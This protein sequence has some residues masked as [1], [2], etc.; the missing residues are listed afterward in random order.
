MGND[1]RRTGG[2]GDALGASV[3]AVVQNYPAQATTHLEGI[4]GAFG[5][6]DLP[7]LGAEVLALATV[8]LWPALLAAAIGYVAYRLFRIFF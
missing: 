7:A 8:S 4:S 1:Q 3:A 6:G 2:R 5:R